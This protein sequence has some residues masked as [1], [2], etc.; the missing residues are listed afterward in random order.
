[1]S[2]FK[3]FTARGKHGKTFPVY[4]YIDKNAQ[5]LNLCVPSMFALKTR[6]AAKL[7]MLSA[8]YLGHAIANREFL[9][10]RKSDPCRDYVATVL[11]SL[12][13]EDSEDAATT[14]QHE[15]PTPHTWKAGTATFG[16]QYQYYYGID[17]WVTARLSDRIQQS[18]LSPFGECFDDSGMDTS[19]W[20]VTGSGVRKLAAEWPEI[21]A[22]FGIAPEMAGQHPPAADGGR[23]D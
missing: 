5:G 15:E 11:L 10:T 7:D 2:C 4:Q 6:P 21:A 22:E 12:L 1:M 17:F 19:T 20:L 13:A 3:A 18:L 14:P 9:Q 16:E 8:Y 23:R